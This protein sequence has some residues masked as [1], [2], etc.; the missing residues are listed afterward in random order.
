MGISGRNIIKNFDPLFRFLSVRAS[1]VV[2]W[3][4]VLLQVFYKSVPYKHAFKCAWPSSVLAFKSFACTSHQGMNNLL[5][6]SIKWKKSKV[7][8]LISSS[9]WDNLFKSPTNK[10]LTEI[11]KNRIDIALTK[12]YIETT[13]DLDSANFS[14]LVNIVDMHL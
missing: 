10:Y 9:V 7:P 4:E 3:H 13:Y 6:A 12:S 1:L 5:L 11:C 2:V 14:L 8:I